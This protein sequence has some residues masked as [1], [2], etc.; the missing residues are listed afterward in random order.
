MRKTLT[1]IKAELNPTESPEKLEKA[2]KNMFGEI[3]VNQEKIR[4]ETYLTATVEELDKLKHFREILARE[5][6]RDAVRLMFSR[7]SSDEEGLSFNL[8]RQAAYVGHISIYH[9][10][11]APL[12][13]IQVKME[14]DSEQIIDY[15]CGKK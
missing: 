2:I 11:K 5:R 7:W 15:L 9:A 6:I 14:G 4:G 12:G 8:N 13:P 10:N 3:S 1:K